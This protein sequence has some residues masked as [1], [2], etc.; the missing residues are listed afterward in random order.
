MNKAI[1]KSNEEILLLLTLPTNLG[2]RRSKT[3]AGRKIQ[4][5]VVFRVELTKWIEDA[6]K[7]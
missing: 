6:L 2:G 7:A 5:R 1:L 3:E 4:E